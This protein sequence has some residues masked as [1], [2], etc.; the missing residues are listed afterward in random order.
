MYGVAELPPVSA[1]SASPRAPW[2]RTPDA[3]SASGSASRCAGGSSAFAGGSPASAAGAA[4]DS[5]VAFARVT[6]PS[7]SAT[8]RSRGLTDTLS[9][10]AVAAAVR[11]VVSV[12]ER[13]SR[14]SPT[15]GTSTSVVPPV[16]SVTFLPRTVTAP[17]R[18]A[19]ATGFFPASQVATEVTCSTSTTDSSGRPGTWSLAR[20]RLV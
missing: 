18:F 19:S 14:T 8:F 5:Q 10:S 6:V 16:V 9:S 13:S 1:R 20:A 3:G 4:G 2:A 17:S 12:L 15:P 7:T 11:D